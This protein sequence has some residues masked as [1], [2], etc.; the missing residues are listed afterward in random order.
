MVVLKYKS[1][2]KVVNKEH[3]QVVIEIKCKMKTNRLSLNESVSHSEI[4]RPG[5][6]LAPISWRLN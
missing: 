1:G 4:N 5:D 2:E 3:N 6:P